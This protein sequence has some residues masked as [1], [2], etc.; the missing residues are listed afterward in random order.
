MGT[1]AFL[2]PAHVACPTSSDGFATAVPLVHT[3][4]AVRTC[5]APTATIHR[6]ISV[7]KGACHQMTYQTSHTNPLQDREKALLSHPLVVTLYSSCLRALQP[8]LHLLCTPGSSLDARFGP[9]CPRQ[10]TH[11]CRVGHPGPLAALR[12]PRP[13][14]AL[15]PSMETDSEE[16]ESRNII[17]Y[18]FCYIHT[19]TDERN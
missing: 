3:L 1:P 12:Y 4:L 18:R 13:G 10:G 11:R 9:I 15:R 2:L 5:S 6:N 7:E 14:P 17:R 16:R 19:Y 8:I